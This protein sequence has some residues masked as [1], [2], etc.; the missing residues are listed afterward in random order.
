[1]TALVTCAHAGLLPW[2]LLGRGA[3]FKS[4]AK[5]A[6]KRRAECRESL[7]ALA[8]HK[9]LLTRIYV[10]ECVDHRMP[11]YIARRKDCS[12]HVSRNSLTCANKGVQEFVNIGNF[13]RQAEIPDHEMIIKLTA[14]YLIQRP[15]FLIY[16]AAS[17][18]VAV[19]RKDSDVWGERGKGVHTFLFAARKHVL[20]SFA[21]WLLD[22]NRYRSIGLTP[23][24]WV[25][26]DYL[27]DSGLD[28]SYYPDRLHVLARYSP[29]LTYI[30]V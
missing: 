29:P 21:A 28:V 2:L 12:S 5:N 9:N 30:N 27:V 11:L 1:M 26:G 8:A 17:P 19:V 6:K 18:S 23:I 25:F 14:R 22:G 4:I 3:A 10:V 20:V 7:D 16:A 15:D 13:L 24:E